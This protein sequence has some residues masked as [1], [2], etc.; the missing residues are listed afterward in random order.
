MLP[1]SDTALITAQCEAWS[2]AEHAAEARVE[3]V[4]HGSTVDIIEASR[5][6]A[7]RDDDWLRVEC[8]RLTY[9]A[10]TGLWTLYCFDRD[11]R[12]MRYDKWEPDFVQ[13]GTV[14]EILA[15]I[16]ADPTNVFWG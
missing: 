2:P 13:P 10:G 4:V 8:A 7:E 12:A 3:S 5:M 6:G 14:R 9:D 11:S 15:E 16:D 1:E